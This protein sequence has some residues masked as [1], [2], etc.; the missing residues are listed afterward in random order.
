MSD[1]VI[2]Y[3]S[4]ASD[5]VIE[6]EVLNRAITEIPT[7]LAWR[8]LQ[9]PL[10]AQEPEMKALA[11]VNLHLL[12]LGSDVRAPVGVEWAAARR[13]N[14][15]PTLYLK[16][17]IARTQAAQAFERELARY[18]HWQ[19]YITIG[20]I[21]RK[22]LLLVSRHILS[23]WEYYSLS[24]DEFDKLGEWRKTLIESRQHNDNVDQTLGGAGNSG[25][26]LSIE[27]YM[28]SEG[29]LLR[30]TSATGVDQVEDTG[31]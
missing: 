6:R 20:D 26:I 11:E 23:R 10:T 28:P 3:L 4:A 25:V 27:R 8:I 31:K 30:N 19:T 17:N 15:L 1:V 29:V 21:R 12:L 22:F 14:R 5:L 13:T 2:I 16:R 18:A 7:S 24:A 9:T